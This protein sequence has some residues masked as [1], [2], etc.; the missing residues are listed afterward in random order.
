MESSLTNSGIYLH[1]PVRDFASIDEF[2]KTKQAESEQLDFKAVVHTKPQ[3]FAKDVAAFANNLGGDLIIG[4]N[5]KDDCA[6]GMNPFE[7][8][9][10]AEHKQHLHQWLITHIRPVAFAE[11]VEM[12][13]VVTP[14]AMKAFL[15]ISIPPSLDLIGV[16]DKQ[17][18]KITYTFPIRTGRRT[19]TLFYEEI[20]ERSKV[21]TRAT[22]IRLSELT[23]NTSQGRIRFSNPVYILTYPGLPNHMPT[24]D[25]AHGDLDSFTSEVIN[26]TMSGSSKPVYGMQTMNSSGRNNPRE[27]VSAPPGKK[28]T[29][30]LELVKAIWRDQDRF[31]CIA[32]TGKIVWDGEY[33]IIIL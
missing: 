11:A 29:I 1:K 22:F 13:E 17:G 23:K 21:S 26:L 16:E 8:N 24:M 15:V 33:W 5:D 28:L 7:R 6:D 30:P 31:L 4:I 10:F 27:E 3:E 12:V 2:V 14:D 9:K 32:V 18:D 19:R 20:M 25:G